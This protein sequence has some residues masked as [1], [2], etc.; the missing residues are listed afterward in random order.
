M[1]ND[2]KCKIPARLSYNFSKNV[3]RS[4][5][6]GEGDQKMLFCNYADTQGCLSLHC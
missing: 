6:L 2:T 4:V 3:L 5:I 1:R